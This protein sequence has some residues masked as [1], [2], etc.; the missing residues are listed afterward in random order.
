MQCEVLALAFL[1]GLYLLTNIHWFGYPAIDVS[2]CDGFARRGDGIVCYSV[3][4]TTGTLEIAQQQ[5]QAAGRT[6][7]SIASSVESATV[8]DLMTS[9]SLVESWIGAVQEDTNWQWI[10]G[11][12]YNWLFSLD[13][14]FIYVIYKLSNSNYNNWLKH[15]KKFSMF[16]CFLIQ[17]FFFSKSRN[18][19]RRPRMLLGQSHFSRN[20]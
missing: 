1:F 6:L 18:W 11:D 12:Y 3:T 13:S 5:C 20:G 19:T 17:L 16:V 15:S 7:L 8:V 14:S 2:T 4:K 10:D 9:N